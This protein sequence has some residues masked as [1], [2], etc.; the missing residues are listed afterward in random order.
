MPTVST[1]KPAAKPA[2]SSNPKLIGAIAAALTLIILGGVA[3]FFFRPQ[4]PSRLAQNTVGKQVVVQDAS[5]TDVQVQTP[6]ELSPINKI[7]VQNPPEALT[8]GLE[9]KKP[10]SELFQDNKSFQFGV[11]KIFFDTD[12]NPRTGGAGKQYR[13]EGFEVLWEAN[14]MADSGGTVGDWANARQT[15]SKAKRH[16]ISSKLLRIRPGTGILQPAD[17]RGLERGK[18]DNK[19]IWLTVS[20]AD[21][22]LVPGQ[23]IRVTIQDLGT[24]DSSVGGELL[25]GFVLKLN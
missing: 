18:L 1:P 17:R 24:S 6:S 5:A 19:Q 15:H 4:D 11:V 20:Y 13:S 8:F 25:P 16:M 2:K 21:L 22:G 3:W 14:L 10:I 23:S 9:L 7:H 12:N